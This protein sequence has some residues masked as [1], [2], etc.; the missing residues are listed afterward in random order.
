MHSSCIAQYVVP[1]QT[2]R[3]DSTTPQIVHL[4]HISYMVESILRSLDYIFFYVSL[5]NLDPESE[6]YHPISKKP[7]TRISSYY[8][9]C[10]HHYHSA[11]AA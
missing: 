6:H 10:M 8:T 2:P 7:N 11:E 5:S 9:Y 1:Y 4:Y 3:L